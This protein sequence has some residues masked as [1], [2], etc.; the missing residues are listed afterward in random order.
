MSFQDSKRGRKKQKNYKIAR[1]QLTRWH[2]LFIITLNVNRLNSPIK[3]YRVT[4]WIKK[5]TNKQKKKSKTQL[6]AAHKRLRSKDT[7]AQSE[8]MVKDIPCKWEPK[9]C[10]GSYT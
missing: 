10:R 3:R 7:Q 6:Y 5:K 8:G 1:K 9:D 4:E 2:Y